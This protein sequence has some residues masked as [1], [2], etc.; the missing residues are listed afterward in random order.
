[1]TDEQTE[2]ILRELRAI[3]VAR[4]TAILLAVF[5][6]TSLKIIEAIV[7]PPPPPTVSVQPP[8]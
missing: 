2:K 3:K 6:F 5:I 1:M 7:G 4:W 8:K